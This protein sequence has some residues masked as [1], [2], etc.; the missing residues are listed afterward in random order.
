MVVSRQD[1]PRTDVRVREPVFRNI[2]VLPW[3]VSS[4]KKAEERVPGRTHMITGYP[5][6]LVA[7]EWLKLLCVVCLLILK[8]RGF[9][10]TVC[11]PM[12]YITLI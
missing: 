9:T 1:L 12:Q 6:C 11:A 5:L 4:D 8:P 2:T 10:L 3:E 7:A